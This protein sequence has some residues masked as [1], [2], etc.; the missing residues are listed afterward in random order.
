MAIPAGPYPAAI[1]YADIAPGMDIE[2]TTVWPAT[3]T[4]SVTRGIVTG[5][6][7]KQL[8]YTN[9]VAAPTAHWALPGATVTYRL[10]AAPV[11]AP[12]PVSDSIVLDDTGAAWQR[13][14]DGSVWQSIHGGLTD[15]AG[16]CA[17]HPTFTLMQDAPIAPL[18]DPVAPYPVTITPDQARVGMDLRVTATYPDGSTQVVRGVCTWNQDNDNTDGVTTDYVTISISTRTDFTYNPTPSG[19]SLLVEQMQE[20][21]D[22]PSVAT[23]N[24]PEPPVGTVVRS[25]LGVAWQRIEDAT[26]DGDF[27]YAGQGQWASVAGDA[28]RAWLWLWGAAAPFVEQEPS[29]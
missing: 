22:T 10:M 2:T 21:P 3:G 11:A 28:P 4:S 8:R 23:V 26:A 17:A 13:Q 7:G 20:W 6:D 14:G 12:E 19:V 18:P 15:W 29:A 24:V 9:S 1:D 27:T 5:A 25:W 16:F